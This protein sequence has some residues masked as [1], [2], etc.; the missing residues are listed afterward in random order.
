MVNEVRPNYTKFH[1]SL[2]SIFKKTTFQEKV[3]NNVILLYNIFNI[4]YLKKNI[5]GKKI[6]QIYW[7]NK[8]EVTIKLYLVMDHWG[9]LANNFYAEFIR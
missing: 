7:L 3:S 2:I 6:K 5:S 4:L 8:C 1:I 9:K